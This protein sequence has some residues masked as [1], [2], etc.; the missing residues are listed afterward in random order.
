MTENRY[1][2]LKAMQDTESWYEYAPSPS[3]FI[4]HNRCC[5]E[6]TAS[7]RQIYEGMGEEINFRGGYCINGEELK[8]LFR[9]WKKQLIECRGKSF[10][11]HGESVSSN[12]GE[13]LR[14]T[15]KGVT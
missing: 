8:L 15:G 2:F 4:V 7:E 5:G 6:C 12:V 11:I 10:K 14:S 1:C 13:E 9:L 3:F